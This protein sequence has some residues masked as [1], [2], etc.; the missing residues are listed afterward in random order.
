MA[1]VGFLVTARASLASLWNFRWPLHRILRRFVSHTANARMSLFRL[2]AIQSIPVPPV[3]LNQD[4]LPF[5]LSSA[6]K[7]QYSISL[8]FVRC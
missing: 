4:L 8:E 7:I 1:I 5:D 3:D 2:F 6:L